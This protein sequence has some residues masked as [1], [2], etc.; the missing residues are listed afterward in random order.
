MTVAPTNTPTWPVP[1]DG[2]WTAEDLDGLPDLPPHTELLDGNLV[3]MSPQ[4]N[5]H[6]AAVSLLHY[7]LLQARP[8]EFKAVREMSLVLD[9]RDRPEPDVMV[10]HAEA[11]RDRTQTF[12]RPEDVVL[13]VEVVSPDSMERDEEL[14]PR[15]YAAAG[16][17]HYWLVEN[18]NGEPVVHVYELDPVA[19]SYESKGAH[20]GVLNLSAPFPLTID[21]GRMDDW[22]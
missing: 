8:E 5:F 15:K 13:A 2:G 10:V 9:K 1:P 20:R 18:E 11:M 16:I 19:R 6:Y 22:S 12:Y 7:G 3:F 14:K 21:L 17:K 4:R